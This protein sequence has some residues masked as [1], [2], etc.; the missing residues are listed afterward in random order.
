MRGRYRR[1]ER[2]REKE[3]RKGKE[4]IREGGRE[5]TTSLHRETCAAPSD[6]YGS[7]F[8][9]NTAQYVE[10]VKKELTT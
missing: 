9:S 8:L 10:A 2:E 5:K 1:R 4:R 3:G 7:I 6:C